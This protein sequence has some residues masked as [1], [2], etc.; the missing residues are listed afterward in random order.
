MSQITAGC[1]V[2]IMYYLRNRIRSTSGLPRPLRVN[3]GTCPA[4]LTDYYLN[5]RIMDIDTC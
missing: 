4:G 1:K 2:C 5:E 3:R